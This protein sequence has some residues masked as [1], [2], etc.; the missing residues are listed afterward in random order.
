MATEEKVTKSEKEIKDDRDL[1]QLARKQFQEAVDSD[2]HNRILSQEDLEFCYDIDGGQWD[3]TSRTNREAKR[4]PCLT[5]N[6]VRKFAAGV[7]NRQRMNRMAMD[8][9]P[10]DDLADVKTAKVYDGILRQIESQSKAEI[11]YADTGEKALAGGFGFWRLK[12]M[13]PEDGFDQD[14]F[15][16]GIDNQFSVHLDPEGNYG[17]IRKPIITAIFEDQYPNAAKVDF[18]QSSFGNDW[19]LWYTSDKIFIAEWFRKVPYM[20]TIAKVLPPDKVVPMIVELTK[21]MTAAHLEAVNIKVQKIRQYKSYKVMWYKITGHEILEREAWAGNEIPIIEVKGDE[22][23]INGKKHK[24]SMIR[25]AKGPQILYNYS[26]TALA[27]KISSVP[28]APYILTPEMI[29]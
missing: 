6:K 29:K 4:R 1:L 24:R 23:N 8:T 7:A 20:K 22:V 26:V 27:E 16:E 12:T 21:E 11:I 17:F 10:V 15:I 9:V 5:H 13:I 19:E 18:D 2:F 25:D 14:I 3:E 28:K